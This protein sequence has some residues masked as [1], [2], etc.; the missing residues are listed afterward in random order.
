[1]ALC[2]GRLVFESYLEHVFEVVVAV[3]F[4]GNHRFRTRYSFD[5]RKVLRDDRCKLVS[6]LY[7]DD[8][9]EVEVAGHRVNLCHTTDLE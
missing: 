6:F 3:A 7:A 8:G 9:Y 4:E 1:M 2:A 5:F